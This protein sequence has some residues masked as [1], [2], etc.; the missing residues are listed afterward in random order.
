[1]DNRQA[2]V[3]RGVVAGALAAIA[4]LA[5]AVC[6][7]H[8]LNAYSL[9]GT[10]LLDNCAA[11]DAQA[12]GEA[13]I[14]EDVYR[15]G[16]ALHIVG[17]WP[18]RDVAQANVR[19]GLV[20]TPWASGQEEA[21]VTLLNTE[22]VR[23]FELGGA[24]DDHCGFHAAVLIKTLRTDG[25]YRAVLLDERDGA[26]RRVETDVA[27]IS[28]SEGGVSVARKTKPEEARHE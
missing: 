17:L 20:F 11:Y 18:R 9:R 28:L 5:I 8:G 22:M 3:R 14:V 13:P 15:Q 12:A 2:P 25:Q 21:S 1:M 7:L 26:L 27:G 19:V 6:A 4:L 24:Y 10:V 23:R 16:G